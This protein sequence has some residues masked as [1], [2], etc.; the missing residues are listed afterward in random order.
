ML[1]NMIQVNKKNVISIGNTQKAMPNKIL[2]SIEFVGGE[3][4]KYV[5][6]KES[7]Y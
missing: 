2:S 3:K 4:W 1:Q 7:K 6:E 5:T